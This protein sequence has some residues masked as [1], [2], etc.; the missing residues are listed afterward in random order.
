MAVLENGNL[1]SAGTIYLNIIDPIEGLIINTLAGHTNSISVGKN[2]LLMSG[3]DDQTIKI[4]NVNDVTLVKT[5]YAFDYWVRAVAVL[6]N[7][8]LA[9]AGK[10]LDNY[11]IKIWNSDGRLEKTITG[12]KKDIISLAVLQNGNLAS[13]DELGEIRIWNVTDGAFVFD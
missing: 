11:K 4:W 6:P 8:N 5:I 13:G 10:D 2:G 7:G 3:S 1:A 12:Y 9:S